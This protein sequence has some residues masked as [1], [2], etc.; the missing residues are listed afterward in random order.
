MHASGLDP[1]EPLA[2][3]PH[4]PLRD[5]AHRALWLGVSALVYRLALTPFHGVRCVIV[6]LFGAT[7]AEGAMPYATAR[8]WAR[9]KLGCE[10]TAA[11]RVGSDAT[12]WPASSIGGLHC[13]P[14]R[15]TVHCDP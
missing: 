7:I 8:I 1:A 13:E 2:V 14:A 11:W 3:P 15:I 12:T 6:R 5:K 9:W 10:A 4:P